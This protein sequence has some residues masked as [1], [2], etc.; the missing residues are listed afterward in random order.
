MDDD[1]IVDLYWERSELAISETEKKYG[2]YCTTIAVNILHNGEDAKEC[3]N[4]TFLKTWEAIPPRRPT[5]FRG[6]LGKITRNLSLDM[7]RKSKAQKRGGG[8]IDLLFGEL[9]D[10]IP[11]SETVESQQESEMIAQAINDCLLSMKSTTMVVFVRRYWYAESI[12]AIAARFNM[13][14][15]AVKTMLFRARKKLKEHL[16][17]EGVM[18]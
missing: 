3:V 13:S 6:F 18:I 7:Y 8:E 4:D 15:S 10:C 12:Q 2:S 11:A 1:K 14:E 9:E 16:E 5:F 17:K